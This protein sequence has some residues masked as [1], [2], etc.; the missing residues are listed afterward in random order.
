[1][2]D[3]AIYRKYEHLSARNLLYLRSE[4][5]ELEGQLEELDAQDVKERNTH[6]QESQKIARLWHHYSRAESERAIQHRELQAEI[7]LKLKT[8]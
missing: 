1:D 8:Y 6:D 3:A 4:L 2:A 7:R 5:H